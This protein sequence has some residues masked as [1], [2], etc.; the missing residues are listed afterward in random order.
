MSVPARAHAD[1][2]PLGVQVVGSYGGDE[3]VLEVAR[4]LE[5]AAS[6][7]RPPFPAW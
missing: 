3:T 7:T 1:G 6:W 5:C 2:W 4:R